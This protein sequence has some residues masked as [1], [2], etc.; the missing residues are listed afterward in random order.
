MQGGE[1]ADYFDCGKGVDMIIDFN[2]EQGDD[3]VGNCEQI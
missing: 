2:S 1:G 3:N